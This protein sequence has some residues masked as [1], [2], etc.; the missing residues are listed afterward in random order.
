MR[1]NPN[2]M[3]NQAG[4]TLIEVLVT[5][6]IVAIGLLGLASLQ[7]STMNDQ[8]EA[9]QR[10]RATA[11]VDDMAERIRMN[12]SDVALYTATSGP[13]YG[14]QSTATIC[15]A[16]EGP[17]R[18]LCD[19]NEVIAGISEQ[20]LDSEGAA[21]ANLGQPLNARGCIETLAGA[22]GSGETI[23]RVTV[24]WQGITQSVPPSVTCGEDNY[25]A[26]D[27]GFRRA[28]FRDVAVR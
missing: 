14:G 15:T 20:T 3:A 25:G 27:E 4:F 10:S 2:S 17:A 24:V 22:G 26:E 28:V 16:F 12:P 11:I 23:V 18:D 1:M 5:F 7:V 9:L 6:V 13:I 21:S 19:W 8:F